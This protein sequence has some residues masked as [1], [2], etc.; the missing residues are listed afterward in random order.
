MNILMAVSERFAQ[1]IEVLNFNPNSLSKKLGVTQP[2][3]KKLETGATLPNG[4][5]L[6]PLLELFNVN[7]NWLLGGKGEMFLSDHTSS[8]Q[9]IINRDGNFTQVANN[10]NNTTNSN[11]SNSTEVEYL[12]SKIDDLNKVIKSQESQLDDKNEIIKLLKTK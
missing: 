10:S 7:I 5:V 2:T 4:K 12:K 3:I 9:K 6:I 8:S 1:L 11:N